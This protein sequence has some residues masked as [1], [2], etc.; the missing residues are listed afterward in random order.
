[1]E[2]I[3]LIVI[4]LKIHN[5]KWDTK[6]DAID[7]LT[8]FDQHIGNSAGR[9]R[10]L[11]MLGIDTEMLIKKDSKTI[12]PWELGYPQEREPNSLTTGRGDGTFD[13][14][15]D[16]YATELCTK[17]IHC[18]ELLLEYLGYAFNWQNRRIGSATLDA[19]AIY[20]VPEAVEK[21]APDE[22]KRLGCMPSTNIYGDA[23]DPSS[24]ASTSRTTGCHL[25]ISHPSLK[26]EDVAIALVKWADILVGSTW[27]YISP[28]PSKAE[29]DRRKA[30]GRAGEFRLK[31]YPVYPLTDASDQHSNGV[32]YRVL[33]GTPIHHPAYLTLM[34]SLY[35]SALRLANV[36]GE[37]QPELSAQA[38]EAIN[39]ADRKAA[40]SII[41]SLP[42]SPGGRKL[43]RFL[44]RIPLKTQSLADWYTLSR[45]MKGHTKL[46][47]EAHLA[48]RSLSL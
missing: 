17:P 11:A 27:T 1:M 25:H 6:A 43:I 22:A 35:R 28:N 36:H 4:K 42:L 14:H 20:D 12:W 24:L 8:S 34:F 40:K 39:S 3:A 7:P 48:D 23:G 5:G 15:G 44:R 10:S 21:A 32:E 41:R 47:S 46:Y 30:Y 9:D 29:A 26:S 16:G 18:L 31:R 33:P 13:F 38:Q 19:P 2:V 45:G 37:P